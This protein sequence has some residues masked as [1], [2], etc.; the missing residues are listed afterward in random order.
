M[1]DSITI[2]RKEYDALLAAAETLAQRLHAS[3]SAEQRAAVC[4]PWDF[5]HPKHG[6]LHQMA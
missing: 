5:M 6:L 3:L 4:V 1:P 2:P